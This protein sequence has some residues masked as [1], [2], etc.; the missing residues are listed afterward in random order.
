M[1]VGT[2]L[3]AVGGLFV[4]CQVHLP[5]GDVETQGTIENHHTSTEFGRQHAWCWAYRE[6]VV[7][8]H[9]ADGLQIILVLD[10]T[11]HNVSTDWIAYFSGLQLAFQLIHTYFSEFVIGTVG[12]ASDCERGR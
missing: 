8:L 3:I 7:H 12:L 1:P 10:N 6:V 4:R 5:L 11:A 9:W 2:S